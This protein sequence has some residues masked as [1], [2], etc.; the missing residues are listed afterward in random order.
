[1]SEIQN[2]MSK[3]QDEIYRHKYYVDL[4][5]SALSTHNMSTASIDQGEFKDQKIIRMCNTFWDSLPD[6]PDIRRFPF[7]LLCEIAEQIF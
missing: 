6:S 7:F 4:Y 2:K 1:M 3:L 5:H